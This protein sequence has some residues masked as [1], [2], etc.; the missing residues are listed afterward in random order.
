MRIDIDLAA[1]AKAVETPA[2]AFDYVRSFFP[3]AKFPCIDARRYH[4][5]IVNAGKSIGHF[6]NN[7]P[8]YVPV[9]H[10]WEYVG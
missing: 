2:Q 7:G 10:E 9:V 4:Y 6:R 5:R 1:A 3:E 8:D